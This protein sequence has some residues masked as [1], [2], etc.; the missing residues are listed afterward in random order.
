[1]RQ[2]RAG[3]P[4]GGRGERWR[5]WTVGLALLQILAVVCLSLGPLEQVELATQ[6]LRLRACPLPPTTPPIVLVGINP[7]T[8][9]QFPEAPELFWGHL[10]AEAIQE[11]VRLGARVVG[12]DIIQVRSADEFLDRVKASDAESVVGEGGRPDLRLAEAIQA[13]R[14]QERH[15][16]LG[17]G[18]QS[19]LR[20]IPLLARTGAD[21]G[22]VDRGPDDAGAK[23]DRPDLAGRDGLRRP[24]AQVAEPGGVTRHSQLWAGQEGRVLPSFPASIA[25]R[26]ANKNPQD[27]RDLESLE[28]PLAGGVWPHSFRIWFRGGSVRT[29]QSRFT[30]CRFEDLVKLNL[31]AEDRLA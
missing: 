1:M 30:V 29:G 25:L 15:V 23:S 18:L 13:A 26:M 21:L 24:T 5:R 8:Y 22:F 31:S 14:K 7:D 20:P 10:R 19:G 3:S 4:R 16:V 12:L 27:P 17:W 9:N 11:A 2:A 6:D 28:Q